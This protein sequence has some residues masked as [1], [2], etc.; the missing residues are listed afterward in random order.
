[1]TKTEDIKRLLA[2]YYDGLTTEEEENTLRTYFNGND[3]DASLKDESIFFTA[4]QSSECPTPAGMEE[5]LSRQINQWNT[6]EVTNRR[7]IRHIN[8][9]WI[10]GIAASLLLLFATGAIVYQNEN[11]SPQTEQDTY[12]NA[13][14]A[15]AETSKALM[16]FSKTLNKGIDATEN[17][18]N[19]TRD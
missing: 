11:K 2:Q 10:V 13:K 4:L 15:Y 17:I 8:L 14:D 12:T 1:M 9:R 3:I 16:K 18:T 19:K 6:L 7:A 5:R